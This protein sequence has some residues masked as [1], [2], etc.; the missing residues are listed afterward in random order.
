MRALIFDFDGLILDTERPEVETW[1]EVF[2][3]HGCEFPDS[4]WM[5][6]LGKPADQVSTHPL[7]LLEEQIGPLPDRAGL[8]DS[9]RRT[10]LD[11]IDAQE[12]RPGVV[13]LAKECRSSGIRTAVASSSFHDWVD[14]YLA[15]H[16]VRDLFEEVVCIEDVPRGKPYPDLY[17]EALHRLGVNPCDAAALEDSPNGI[18]AAKA[19]GLL[20]IAVP[21]TVTALC[22]L[23][24]ADKVVD[25]LA[26]VDLPYLSSLFNCNQ[27]STSRNL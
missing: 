10:L 1:R 11:A 16:G 15:R 24:Q 5:E 21:N 7:D 20:C 14:G 18:R 23:S 2:R 3:Q 17:L 8:Q 9:H 22:D 4:W 25:S 26:D 27:H 19:A 13:G 6:A 12:L